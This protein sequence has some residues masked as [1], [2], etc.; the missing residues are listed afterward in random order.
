MSEFICGLPGHTAPAGPP[1]VQPETAAAPE[2][3][4]CIR[5]SC[6]H[7]HQ[8]H[9]PPCQPATAEVLSARL[10]RIEQESCWRGQDY[11]TVPG[12]QPHSC[13]LCHPEDHPEPD[14]CYREPDVAYEG[15]AGLA[16]PYPAEDAEDR[17]PLNIT[18]AEM[19]QYVIDSYEPVEPPEDDD[20]EDC[21][22]EL[23][24]DWRDR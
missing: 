23:D 17:W 18:E 2:P 21:G 24:P 7:W 15:G 10:K 12:N 9:Q 11:A 4:P 5:I 1:A 6:V 14:I 13:R 19:S 3:W 20:H 8:V 16:D 22:F